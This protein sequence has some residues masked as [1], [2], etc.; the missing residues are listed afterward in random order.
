M[1]LSKLSPQG[2]VWEDRRSRRKTTAVSSA[3]VSRRTFLRAA[4]GSSALVLSGCV[5]HDSSA[6]RAPA[7]LPSGSPTSGGS[8]R[9][10]SAIDTHIHLVHGN[11]DLKPIPEE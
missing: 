10:G 8:L 6:V 3:R 7:M 2:P 5:S 11:P 9:S 1:K 4:F